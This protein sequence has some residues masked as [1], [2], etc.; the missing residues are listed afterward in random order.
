M[1]EIEAFKLKLELKQQ[2]DEVRE[3]IYFSIRIIEILV[4][5]LYLV[6]TIALVS[7]TFLILGGFLVLL[8]IMIVLEGLFKTDEEVIIKTDKK[9]EKEEKEV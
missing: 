6:F 7:S 3:E 4:L 5:A 1:T 8:A 9:S 2:I